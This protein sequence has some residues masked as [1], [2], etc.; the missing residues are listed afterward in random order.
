MHITIPDGIYSLD[1]LNSTLGREFANLG[2]ASNIILLSPDGPTSR[3]ILTY[4]IA[5]LDVDFTQANTVRTVLG[6]NSRESPAIPPSVA[7]ES[8][9]SDNPAAFNQINSFYVGH[10]SSR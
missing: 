5:G 7:G 10:L 9:Y 3:S 4:T 6:F 2:F 1:D 8:D